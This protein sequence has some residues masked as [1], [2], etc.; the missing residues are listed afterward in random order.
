LDGHVNTTAGAAVTVKVALQLTG[1]SQELVTVN[2]AVA[3]P[4]QA[5]GAPLFIFEIEALHP[6]LKE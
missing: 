5:D 3:I 1:D 6:P 4:P 2:V